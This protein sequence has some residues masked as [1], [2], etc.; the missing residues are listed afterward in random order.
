MNIVNGIGVRLLNNDRSNT[1][2]QCEEEEE[3]NK[4]DE[5]RNRVCNEKLQKNQF[6]VKRKEK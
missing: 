4:E 6:A 3:S 2:W 5:E 1:R